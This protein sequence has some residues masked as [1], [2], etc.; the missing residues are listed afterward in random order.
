MSIDMTEL[1]DKQNE[2]VQVSVLFMLLNLA[3]IALGNL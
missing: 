2:S 1:E 3:M